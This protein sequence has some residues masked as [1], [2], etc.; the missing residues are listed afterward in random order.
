[1]QRSRDVL[2]RARAFGFRLVFR[3]DKSTT[4]WAWRQDGQECA[5]GFPSRTL[6]LEY[7]EDRLRRL[8]YFT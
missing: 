8:T 2:A 1:M 5:A 4:P 6:A 7:I 3:D